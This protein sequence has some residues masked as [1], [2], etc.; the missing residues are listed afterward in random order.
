MKNI[1]FRY[2]GA[3][4][5]SFPLRIVHTEIDGSHSYGL[6]LQ[7]IEVLEKGVVQPIYKPILT[8]SSHAGQTTI[9]LF[10]FGRVVQVVLQGKSPVISF[11]VCHTEVNHGHR[12]DE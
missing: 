5:A 1:I 3:D 10:L 12:S 11:S 8:V 9:D 7:A 4:I 6:V 2:K